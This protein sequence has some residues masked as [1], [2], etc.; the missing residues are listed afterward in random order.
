[1][2]QSKPGNRIRLRIINTAGDTATLPSTLDGVVTDGGRLKAAESVLLTATKPDRLHTMR[3]TGSMAKYDWSINRRRFN[4]KKPF[5][6]AFNIR[7]D[8]RVQVKIVNDTAMWHPMHLHGHSFQL[9]G[10]GA[11]KDTIIVRPKETVTFEFDADN[12]GQW[13]THCHNAYH[14]EQGM[15]GLFSY[16][17]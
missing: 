13:I 5:A 16:V 8:E 17:R 7:L 1:M 2:L 12:P 9:N 3:L 10:N 6:G 14:A 11:R 15:M 4:M